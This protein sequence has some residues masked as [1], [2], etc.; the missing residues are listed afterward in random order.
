MAITHSNQTVLRRGYYYEA[1]RRGMCVET[2][3]RKG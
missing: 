1:K 2:G 3:L